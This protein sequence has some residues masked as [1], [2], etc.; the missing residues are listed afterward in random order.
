MK[1]LLLGFCVAAAA[2]FNAHQ[3]MAQDAVADSASREGKSHPLMVYDATGK[4]AGQ[5]FPAGPVPSAILNIEGTLI[6][7]NL[8]SVTQN[9]QGDAVSLKWD[10]SGPA[11]EFPLPGCS[12]TPLIYTHVPGTRAIALIRDA[13]SGKLIVYIGQAGLSTSQNFQ[14]VTNPDNPTLCASGG[15]SG[16]V[17][18]WPLDKTVNISDL[19]P[20]PLT[21]R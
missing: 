2:A 5:Y 16:T 6:R 4:P 7:L 10:S 3:L 20:E 18:A 12:G 19:Y 11:V 8:S 13:A 15:S 21:V 9:G 17:N 1:K 14:S